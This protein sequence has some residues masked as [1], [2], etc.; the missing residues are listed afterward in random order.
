[1]IGLRAQANGSKILETVRQV[2][3]I[4]RVHGCI[5]SIRRIL[6]LG[7]PKELVKLNGATTNPTEPFVLQTSDIET[8]TTVLTWV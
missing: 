8:Q 6:P 4:R 5:G 7:I 2:R 3:V 1:M